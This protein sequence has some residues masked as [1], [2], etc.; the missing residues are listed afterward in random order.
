MPR[1]VPNRMHKSA[2]PELLV[3]NRLKAGKYRFRLVVVDGAGNQSNPTELEVTVKAARRRN[4]RDILRDRVVRDRIVV[5]PVRVRGRR[6][7]RT[8]PASPTSP[9]PTPSPPA[10]TTRVRRRRRPAT[11]TNPRRPT[12]PR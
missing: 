2:K 6:T 7:V 9:P 1:L 8:P 11:R 10:S 4:P 5:D 3:E 12:R